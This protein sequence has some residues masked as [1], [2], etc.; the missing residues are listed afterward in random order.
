MGSVWQPREESPIEPLDALIRA[1]RRLLPAVQANGA[2]SKSFTLDLGDWGERAEVALS[3]ALGS[4]SSFAGRTV[5]AYV[6]NGSIA[7]AGQQRRFG[8]EAV[9]DLE[10]GAVLA[11]EFDTV[12]PARA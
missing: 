2:F 6:F 10:T 3:G 7:G 11:M 8:G 12:P 9:L 4:R 1:A 5:V